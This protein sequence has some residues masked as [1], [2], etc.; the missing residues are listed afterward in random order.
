MDSSSENV[1]HIQ[2]NWVDR[3]LVSMVQLNLMRI[4]SFLDEFD[5]NAR[6]KISLLNQK[7]RRL[8]VSLEQCESRVSSK[9]NN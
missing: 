3:E 9:S 7:L 4:I 2:K 5:T 1:D 8:E 6:N